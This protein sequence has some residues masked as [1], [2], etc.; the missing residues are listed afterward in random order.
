VAA[1]TDPARLP[2]AALGVALSRRATLSY[3]VGYAR[4]H[5]YGL[6]SQRFGKWIGDNLKGLAVG[7][8]VGALVLWVP[9]WLLGKSPQRW[10]L[11]TGMLALP[12][13]TLT[14]LISPLWIAPL[15]NKFG[16]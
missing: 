8:V 15:F 11:W 1:S 7:L 14:L 3:Y 6:S 4:E 5:A 2:G 10:W 12:F 16:P 9:Y 13:Y